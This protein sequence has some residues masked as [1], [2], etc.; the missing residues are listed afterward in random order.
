MGRNEFM[1][2][3]RKYHRIKLKHIQR[4][5]DPHRNAFVSDCGLFAVHKGFGSDWWTLSHIPT[6]HSFGA[7]SFE[8]QKKARD[9]AKAIKPLL[10]WK[11]LKVKVCQNNHRMTTQT[12]LPKG[13]SHNVIEQIK[14]IRKQYL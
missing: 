7:S 12:L 11:K 6:G 13:C 1:K 9:F 2:F 8:T 14:E 5:T 4:G 3:S 10:D